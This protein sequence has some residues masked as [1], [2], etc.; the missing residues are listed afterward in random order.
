MDYWILRVLVLNLLGVTV[1]VATI[2][3][4][5]VSTKGWPMVLGPRSYLGL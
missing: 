3:S 4:K 2:R 5:S 1:E